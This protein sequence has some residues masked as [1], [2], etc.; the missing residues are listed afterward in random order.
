MLQVNGAQSTLVGV[1]Q[2]PAP[3]QRTAPICVDP[4]QIWD[5]PQDVV[6]L[7]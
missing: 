7:G 4:T 3:S 5:E 6:L 2:V 1:W